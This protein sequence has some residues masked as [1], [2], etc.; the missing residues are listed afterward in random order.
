MISGACARSNSAAQTDHVTCGLH[1]NDSD[2]K[3]YLTPA[4]YEINALHGCL[5]LLVG[6]S[7]EILSHQL[8]VI[9]MEFLH[10]QEKL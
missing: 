10:E 1:F 7:T 8:S 9:G 5:Q 2:Y 6:S 3:H 4:E